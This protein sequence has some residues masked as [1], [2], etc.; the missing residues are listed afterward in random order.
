MSEYLREVTD[1]LNYKNIVPTVELPGIPIPESDPV[2][3]MS[4]LLPKSQSVDGKNMGI[5]IK[6]EI[7]VVR[8]PFEYDSALP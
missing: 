6:K 8:L 5:E 3:R 2:T 4:L 1:L 7:K